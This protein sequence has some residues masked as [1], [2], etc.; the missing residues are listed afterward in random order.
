MQ[1]LV[2][3]NENSRRIGESHPRA[4][5]LDSEVDLALELLESGMSLS[6]VAKK[7]DV[8]KSCVAHIASGR[9]RGQPIARLVRVSVAE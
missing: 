3:L 4:K 6:C 1:K 2:A 7:M 9:R 8:S 5:L